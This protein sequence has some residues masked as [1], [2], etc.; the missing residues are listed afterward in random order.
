MHGPFMHYYAEKKL[1]VHCEY[2]EGLLMRYGKEEFSGSF[3][4]IYFI[5]KSG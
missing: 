2:I 5:G 4:K 1:W 3:I